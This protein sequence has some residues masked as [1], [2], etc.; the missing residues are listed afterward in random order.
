MKLLLALLSIT[1]TALALHF[2][3]GPVVSN[4]NLTACCP[5]GCGDFVGEVY[6]TVNITGRTQDP[7]CDLW[8]MHQGDNWFFIHTETEFK[9]CNFS[10]NAL[11]GAQT[12]VIIEDINTW[13]TEGETS[14][15]PVAEL[16]DEMIEPGGGRLFLMR[17]LLLHEN[18]WPKMLP[19]ILTQ[20]STLPTLLTALLATSQASATDL[21]GC[22]DAGCGRNYVVV[23]PGVSVVGGV[24]GSD[25]CTMFNLD[26]GSN[27][28]TFT[29]GS[30]YE[31]CNVTV[32][33]SPSEFQIFGIDELVTEGGLTAHCAHVSS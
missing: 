21:S 14:G 28:F 4:D 20:L 5:S 8:A 16:P 3:P 22:C 24:N 29:N 31:Q 9:R 2:G 15:L 30:V 19:T 13:T 17:P 18:S 27:T 25:S 12:K 26:L 32:T 1:S 23:H 33:S 6:N 10:V 7:N 11:E